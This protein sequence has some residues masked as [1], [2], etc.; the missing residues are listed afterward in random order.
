MKQIN[1]NQIQAIL[2]ELFKLNIPTQS[3]TGIQ[4]LLQ[5][6]PEAEDKKSD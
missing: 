2:D 5:E 3:F 4:K 6:L 1:Q